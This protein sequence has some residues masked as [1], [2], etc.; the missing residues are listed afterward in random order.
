MHLGNQMTVVNTNTEK[1]QSCLDFFKSKLK[2]EQFSAWFEPLSVQSYK[3]NTLTLFAPS[4]YFV[5]Q[6]ELRYLRLLTV[7]IREFYGTD[8][9]LYYQFNEINEEP[10]KAIITPKKTTV[11]KTGED[12][13]D[14][15]K[16]FE[17]YLN[18]RYT[19]ENYCQ[20]N[21]N[22]LARSIGEAIA[23][24]PRMQTFNPLFVF[25]PTGVGK[26][27]LIQA[28]GLKIKERNPQ[29]RVL[30]I[31]ARLFESQYTA[32]SLS[33]K[34]NTFIR[35]YQ[36]IDVLIMDDVQDLAMGKKESTQNAFFHI[37]NHLH[38]N[39]RLLIM[40]S[41]CRPS[42][43][44]GFEQRLLSRF[45][46]GATAELEKPDRELRRE[47][48]NMRARQDGLEIP[49]EVLDYVADNVTDS[50][51]ELEGIVVSLLAHATVLNHDID[52]DL[53]RS[54]IANSVKLRK[55]NTPV[56]FE[57][58]TQQVCSH[59]DIDPD[60]IFTS[61]RKREVSD[62][63]QMLMYIAKKHAKMTYTAIGTRLSRKH[64]TVLYACNTIE[65][66]LKHD[67]QL[68]SDVTAIE[69]SLFA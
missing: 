15:Q 41:D 33:G 26:T 6:L 5:E 42:D 62:A 7:G 36:G 68:Q 21:S 61:T 37:F 9:K 1:W 16:E 54:V 8:T 24:N 48:L 64:A 65:Q 11:T 30:Y 52:M 3:D 59:Y 25:G 58:V 31:T 22:K 27:H 53:A 47:V 57:M 49:D 28:I 2:P 50:V 66:R 20:S 45:K 43:M 4:G 44:A 38:Q 32:A 23:K 46:W 40:S 17:S 18:P 12:E 34:V 67:K 39:G 51:R 19:F 56:N 14:V 35:A 10:P 13:R 55:R 29:A 69:K 63:R 60:L